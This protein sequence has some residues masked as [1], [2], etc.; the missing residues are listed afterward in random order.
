MV[1]PVE[2]A[3]AVAAMNSVVGNVSSVVK[4]IVSDV[5][6]FPNSSLA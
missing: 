2:I 5:A 3:M 6:V 4:F 1:M